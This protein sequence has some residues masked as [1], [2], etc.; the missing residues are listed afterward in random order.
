METNRNVTSLPIGCNY[1]I[2]LKS[3]LKKG[4][5]SNRYNKFCNNMT[6]NKKKT[7]KIT[8]S[9]LITINKTIN[10][11]EQDNCKQQHNNTM[12]KCKNVKGERNK[13]C[14]DEEDS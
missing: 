11:V 4:G 13:I 5:K 6:R 8:T 1:A 7:C 14:E 10:V 3:Y 9:S 12:N 2:M